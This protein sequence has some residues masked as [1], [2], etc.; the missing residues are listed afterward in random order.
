[1]RHALCART[2]HTLHAR[3]CRCRVEAS[4]DGQYLLVSWLQRPFSTVVP[5]GRFPVTLELWTR[6][7]TPVRQLAS[8]PLAED[9]PIA[10]NSCRTGEATSV[11]VARVVLHAAWL[12]RACVPVIPCARLRACHAE[13]VRFP[14]AGPRGVSWRDDK[15]AELSWIEAQVRHV[16]HMCMH[17][18]AVICT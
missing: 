3:S 15:P 4:P 18:L 16:C 7:G 17:A 11:S 9:I 5:A 13:P 14:C 6:D 12:E 8:L 10:F 2:R 1:M